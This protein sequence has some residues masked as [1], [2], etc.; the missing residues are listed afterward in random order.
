M[1]PIDHGKQPD[2]PDRDRVKG[3]S[4]WN[5]QN[6]EFQALSDRRFVR[7][8]VWQLI[9]ELISR[10]PK[11][12]RAWLKHAKAADPFYRDGLVRLLK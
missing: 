4:Q 5:Q 11:L 10:D 9:L 2:N 6:R 8:R 1:L 3:Q 12:K 7:D